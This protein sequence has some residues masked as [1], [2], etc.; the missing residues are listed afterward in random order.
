MNVA[1]FTSL[2][3]ALVSVASVAASLYI[4]RRGRESSAELLEIKARLDRM[5]I[6][7]KAMKDIEIE[8]ERLRIRCWELLALAAD[9]FDNPEDR[10][11]GEAAKRFSKQADSFLDKWAEAR[12][13]FPTGISAYLR[14]LR[15]DCRKHTEVVLGIVL[16]MENRTLWDENSILSLAESL[17]RLL[18]G[19]DMF[20]DTVSTVRKAIL[21]DRV[22]D[23]TDP[24]FQH[25]LDDE[26]DE[27][28][29][30]STKRAIGGFRSESEDG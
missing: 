8:S 30:S 11:L 20:I 16:P 7:T 5:D 3:A 24:L 4:A 9:T 23:Q 26:D 14:Q 2:I 13:E 15:H 28:R 1:L 10:R 12:T 6:A 25:A 18:N 27:R 21:N 29:I 22:S 17:R 19:L